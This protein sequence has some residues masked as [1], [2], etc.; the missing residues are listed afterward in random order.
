MQFN[1]EIVTALLVIVVAGL[2][3]Y[4]VHKELNNIGGLVR[5]VK[6]M[7]PKP[8]PSMEPIPERAV[9][10][11]PQQIHIQQSPLPS[12]HIQSSRPAG[13]PQGT[14]LPPQFP[15]TRGNALIKQP[16]LAHV[17]AQMKRA[18]APLHIEE[19][20]Q[21]QPL[22]DLPQEEQQDADQQDGDQQQHQQDEQTK[23]MSD[24]K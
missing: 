15:R 1:K 22:F 2:F 16:P 7:I 19:H 12:Q 20:V 14:G 3:M 23:E 11:P 5:Q 9:E 13:P 17:I 6:Q 8:G 4:Y 18:N 21:E 24:E 10:L